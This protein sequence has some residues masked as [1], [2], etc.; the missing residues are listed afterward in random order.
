MLERPPKPQP[1]WGSLQPNPLECLGAGTQTR[2]SSIRSNSTE[3]T[4][5]YSGP[6]CD[7]FQM[8]FV[9]SEKHQRHV[10]GIESSKCRHFGTL[11]NARCKPQNIGLPPAD[12]LCRKLLG[13]REFI[14]FCTSR[15][16]CGQT[17][18]PDAAGALPPLPGAERT[19]EGQAQLSDVLGW[20]PALPWTQHSG[21][22]PP[23]LPHPGQPLRELVGGIHSHQP[24]LIL[25]T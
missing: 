3:A 11:T 7:V 22:Q 20:V 21:G 17:D 25:P 23:T 18:R 8:L 15:A 12:L 16:S 19:W 5:D 1:A 13:L 4:G 6:L 10:F 2:S 24:S 9:G 14:L